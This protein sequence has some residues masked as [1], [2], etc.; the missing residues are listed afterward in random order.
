M[1]RARVN[2]KDKWHQYSRTGQDAVLNRQLQRAIGAAMSS[3]GV[4]DDDRTIQSPRDLRMEL[5]TLPGGTL[6]NS[7]GV[8]CLHLVSVFDIDLWGHRPD[9]ED[10]F[11]L[12]HHRTPLER[13]LTWFF[14]EG[15]VADDRD[16]NAI[17][18][19]GVLLIRPPVSQLDGID[20]GYRSGK[21]WRCG[22][23][24]MALPT[25]G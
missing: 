5:G 2:E 25:V 22:L 13:L 7:S 23:I 3:P 21:W 8:D 9:A 4:S 19:P 12:H 17:G 20:G 16:V 1:C 10:A 11:A 14:N 24:L 15:A 18:A 6:A